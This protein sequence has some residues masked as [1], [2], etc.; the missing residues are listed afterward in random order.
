M[1]RLVTRILPSPHR[2][3]DVA[4]AAFIGVHATLAMWLGVGLLSFIGISSTKGIVLRFLFFVFASSYVLLL[5]RI[6]KASWSSKAPLIALSISVYAAVVAADRVIEFESRSYFAIAA[7]RAGRFFDD[8]TMVEVVIDDRNTGRRSYPTKGRAVLRHTERGLSVEDDQFFPLSN[9]TNVPIVL[10]NE[11]GSWVRFLSDRRGFR[12]PDK[13]WETGHYETVLIGDS[14]G[15]GA[16][17]EEDDSI[18][19]RMRLIMPQT[20]NLSMDATGPLQ[21]LG[22]MREMLVGKTVDDVIWLFYGGNDLRDLQIE[23]AHPILGRY[24]EPAYSQDL[25]SNMDRIDNVLRQFLNRILQTSQ[26]RSTLTD[27]LS[28]ANLRHEFPVIRREP[29]M[30]PESDVYSLFGK[31]AGMIKIESER[32]NANTLF[33]Y[34]PSYALITAPDALSSEQQGRDRAIVLEIAARAGMEILDVERVLRMN[35]DPLSAFP[36]RINGH[37]SSEGYGLIADSILTRLGHV[38]DAT[39][40]R[41]TVPPRSA[42]G[43][44]P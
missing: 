43:T 39:L 28:L 24:F 14:F 26:V 11:T 33:V 17:V 8:R 7:E 16:C 44:V 15:Q 6:R 25:V 9:V 29:P 23:A 35:S 36:F 30:P 22:T 19:G 32:L 42:G 18:A 5:I 20:L 38:R 41:G 21:Q 12:N 40:P 31:V 27:S 34:L 13:L 1:A 3:G 37:Y 2:V 4:W 10:C